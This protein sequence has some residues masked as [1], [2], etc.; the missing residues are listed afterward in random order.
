[1]SYDDLSRLITSATF[2]VLTTS[3]IAGTAAASELPSPSATAPNTLAIQKPIE[4]ASRRCSV[5]FVKQ[6]RRIP[7]RTCRNEIKRVC[8][9]TRVVRRVPKVVRRCVRI[10][11]RFV[12]WKTTCTVKR[13]WKRVCRSVLVRPPG[14]PARVKRICTQRPVMKRTCRR[15]PSMQTRWVRQCKMHR[16]YVIK[17]SWQRKCRPIVRKTCTMRWRQIC[18]RVPIRQCTPSVSNSLGL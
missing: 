13:T 5:R 7:Q 8:H 12:T 14:R 11:K 3:A 6:C 16:K 10:P 18:R 9:R 1:M 17:V 15:V 4:V 2:A